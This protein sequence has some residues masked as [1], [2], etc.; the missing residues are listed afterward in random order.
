MLELLLGHAE[1]NDAFGMDFLS[2]MAHKVW[3]EPMKILLQ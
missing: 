2:N 1:V 3:H